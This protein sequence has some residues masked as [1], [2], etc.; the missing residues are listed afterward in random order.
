MW[1]KNIVRALTFG[2]KSHQTTPSAPSVDN[3]PNLWCSLPEKFNE[4]DPVED[5]PMYP[6][7]YAKESVAI[8]E[9]TKMS[10]EAKL[11]IVTPFDISHAKEL[12]KLMDEI[13]KRYDG[14]VLYKNFMMSIV[15]TL[16]I[17]MRRSPTTGGNFKYSDE[18]D[19]NIQAYFDKTYPEIKE[20]IEYKKFMKIIKFDS[21]FFV[22]LSIKFGK[23]AR[24]G[25]MLDNVYKSVMANGK[26]PP[27]MSVALHYL[28]IDHEHTHENYVI[29]K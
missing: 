24:P 27:E 16:L 22:T 11:E 20:S 26:N 1:K 13:I 19:E 2:G 4:D 7:D 10:M 21:N 5:H 6:V 18:I 25:F 15:L 9:P 12:M 28:G 3:I 8:L 17:H 29:F 14:S 23:T